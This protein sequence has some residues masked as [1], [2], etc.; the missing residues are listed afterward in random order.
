DMYIK[1]ETTRLDY[2]RNNQSNLRAE[3]YQGIVDSVLKGETRASEVGK[4]IVL[5]ASFM[6]GHEI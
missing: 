4:R 5:P 2:Y 1:L 6:G 3:L